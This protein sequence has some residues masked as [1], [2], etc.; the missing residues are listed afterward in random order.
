[1]GVDLQLDQGILSGVGWDGILEL[2]GMASWSWMPFINDGWATATYYG[3]VIRV[4]LADATRTC[5][6]NGTVEESSPPC[7]Y[8]SYSVKG[9]PAP[10]EAHGARG[11]GHTNQPPASRVLELPNLIIT[12]AGVPL[13]TSP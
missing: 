12:S 8:R 1:M 10:K 6:G 11:K 7:Y 4:S 9:T 2:D 5:L 3:S 13:S